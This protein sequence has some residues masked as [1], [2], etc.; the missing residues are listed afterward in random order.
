MF[1][2]EFQWPAPSL[3]DHLIDEVDLLVE[4]NPKKF[5]SEQVCVTQIVLIEWLKIFFLES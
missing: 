1:S 4:K 5:H 2:L 3:T